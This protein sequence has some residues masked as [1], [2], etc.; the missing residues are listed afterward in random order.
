MY[1]NTSVIR[2]RARELRERAA[3]VRA[4]ADELVARA[5]AVAW[6][7]LAADAMRRAARAHGNRLRACADAHDDAAE[8]LDHHAREVDRVRDL[9]AAIEHR[10][11]GLLH[12][13]GSGVASLVGHVL[14]DG[15]E[16]WA[17]GFD[18][19]PHGHLAW[20]DVRL[21]RSL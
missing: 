7:G 13:V 14:P 11:L 21:P 1:G 18:P 16:H 15:V 10:A 17:R 19:P 8:A 3:D 2:R 4:E 12:H 9:I 5:E 20:L 6:T